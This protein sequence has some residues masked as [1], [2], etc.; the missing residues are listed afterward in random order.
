MSKSYATGSPRWLSIGSV[1]GATRKT[2]DAVRGV[3]LSIE[4]GTAVGLIGPNGAGK[5]TIIKILAGIMR[6]SSGEVIVNGRVPFKDRIKH[7]ASVGVVFGQK[8]QLWWDLPVQQS[9]DL[10]RDVYRLQP[11]QY[12]RTRDDLVERL[13]LEAFLS[14]PVRQLSLGQ[15]MRAEFAAALLH[16][17]SLVILDEPTIGLDALAKIAVR[18]FIHRLVRERGT[19]V[20]LTTHDMHDIEQI[21]DRV[22]LIG[23]GKILADGALDRLR[24]EVFAESELQVEFLG[25]S[26]LLDLPDGI[27]L[28]EQN[29]NRVTVAFDPAKQN[30]A[31]VISKVVAGKPVS[32]I[33]LGPRSIEEFV[34]HFY[35]MHGALEA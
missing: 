10:L 16:E 23:K 9:F 35:R 11:Q 19:T 14:R 2:I 22:L 6:P 5:S 20:L 34:S 31:E 29:G 28:I 4:R 18:E 1:S 15:R 13:A 26:P 27:S 24:S 7:V 25:D 8:T 3:T 33:R 21:V 17:P 30:P 32:D 12:R